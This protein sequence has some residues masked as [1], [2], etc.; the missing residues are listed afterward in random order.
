[1]LTVLN[2]RQFGPEDFEKSDRGGIYLRSAA[3]RRFLAEYERWML[4]GPSKTQKGFRDALREAVQS[5][6]AA[7]RAAD[8]GVYEPFRFGAVPEG[9]DDGGD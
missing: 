5:Y 4:H 3:A 8:P 9:G 2:R 6:A 1:M 7:L